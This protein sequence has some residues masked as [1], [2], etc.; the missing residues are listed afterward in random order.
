MKPNCWDKSE[1]RAYRGL[2]W[3][4]PVLKTISV[5]RYNMFEWFLFCE[6][7]VLTTPGTSM[8]H[9]YIARA[10]RQIYAAALALTKSEARNPDWQP[11][12]KT[13]GLEYQIWIPKLLKQYQKVRC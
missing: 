7:L 9:R 11:Q 12:L 5:I 4:E 2:D 13:F 6:Q 3:T 10:I 1:W 8:E